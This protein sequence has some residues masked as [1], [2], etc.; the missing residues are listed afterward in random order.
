LPVS[1][2]ICTPQKEEKASWSFGLG[3]TWPSWWQLL[4]SLE[5]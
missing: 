5:E 3:S 4:S 2:S 1:R